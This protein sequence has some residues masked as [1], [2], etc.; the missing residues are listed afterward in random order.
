MC[1]Q[2]VLT[3]THRLQLSS[4]ASTIMQHLLSSYHGQFGSTL[5]SRT[6]S[7]LQAKIGRIFRYMK[8]VFSRQLSLRFGL[9]IGLG[10]C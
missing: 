6:R 1:Y 9:G 8:S 3:Q 10:F 4:Q 7:C 2:R 5:E